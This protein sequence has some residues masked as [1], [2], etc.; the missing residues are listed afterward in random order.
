LAETRH[1]ECW[2]DRFALLGELGITHFADVSDRVAAECQ[3]MD[4]PDAAHQ[5]E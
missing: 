3:W 5:E 4:R 1:Y 2:R